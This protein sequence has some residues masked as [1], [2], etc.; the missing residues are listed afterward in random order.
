VI[1]EQIA[2]RTA[3]RDF[4]EFLTCRRC[5]HRIAAVGE[6]FPGAGDADATSAWPPRLGPRFPLRARPG[7]FT[8]EGVEA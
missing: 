1:L 5:R 7:N 3:R 8:G 6:V 2:L 4:G